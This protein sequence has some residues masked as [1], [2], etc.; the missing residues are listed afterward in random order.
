MSKSLNIAESAKGGNVK[1]V[2]LLALA[3]TASAQLIVYTKV[4]PGSNPAYAKITI[5]KAGALTYQEE[6][7]EPEPSEVQLDAPTTAAIFDLAAKLDHFKTKLESGL[8]VARTGDKTYRW[9]EGGSSI[10]T[11]YNHT[12]DETARA[13]QDW[14]ERIS[15]T[16]RILADLERT[17]KYDRLGVNEMVVRLDTA[18]QLKRVVAPE[19]FIPILDR[20]TK[21]ESLLNMA[22]DRA[23]DLSDAFKALKAQ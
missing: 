9:E 13:L 6:P 23:A 14:F 11:K 12:N 5:T 7:I 22:R 20:I 1:T 16:Q 4:F 17:Y 18:W 3:L 15:E 10:E 2:L 21:N 8:K 19:Q